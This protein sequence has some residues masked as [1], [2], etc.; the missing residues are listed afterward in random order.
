MRRLIQSHVA[1][2]QEGVD[3]VCTDGLVRR[4]YPVLAAFVGDHPEQC[5]VACCAE[6][7]YPKCH[8][9]ANQCGATVEFPSCNQVQT[10]HFIAK[11][12]CPVFLPF[13]ANLLHCDIF[14][15]ITSDILHQLHQGIIKDHLKKWCMAIVGK[16]AFDSRFRA[17]PFH[18]GLDHKQ[19]EQ[20]FVT[21]LVGTTP[22]HEVVW[23]SCALIDFVYLAQYHSHSDDTLHALQDA[24]NE[25][26][27][28]KDVFIDLGC[29]EHFNIPKLHSLVHY[30]ESIHQFGSLDG[31]NTE[32]SERLH[33]DYTKKAY[34]ATNRRN[35]TMQMTKWLN[36]Q[37]AVRW[38]NS[39]LTWHN[40][41]HT[42]G[43]SINEHSDDSETDDPTPPADQGSPPSSYHIARRPHFPRQTA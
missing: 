13:W 18:P 5:L 32:N 17:T 20:V 25:F 33:I 9:P 30:V 3:M 26:H 2:G 16:K 8:M 1:A 12:L 6:N 38:F 31:F 28:F 22:N 29:H 35:Y 24:L 10:A 7:W 27:A 36:R 42:T 34:A 14:T 4:V 21:T 23:A 39:Y 19:L 37:E 41:G 15:S 40:N 43:P 11:G